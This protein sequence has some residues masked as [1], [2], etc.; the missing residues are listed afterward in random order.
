MTGRVCAPCPGSAR[1]RNYFCGGASQI[2][3]RGA[4]ERAAWVARFQFDEEGRSA[5]RWNGLSTQARSISDG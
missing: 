3:R 1:R 4:R 2:S 5:G